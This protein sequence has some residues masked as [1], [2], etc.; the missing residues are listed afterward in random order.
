M[1]VILYLADSIKQNGR[2][3]SRQFNCGKYF[4][5]L[6]RININTPYVTTN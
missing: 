1:Q 5:D 3:F 4:F 2:S 6:V